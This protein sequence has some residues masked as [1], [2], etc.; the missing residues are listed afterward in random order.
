[1]W[2]RFLIWNDAGL[3]V[4]MRANVDGTARVELARASNATALAVDHNTGTVYYALSRQIHAVDL[5]ASNK[6]V[7]MLTHP[8]TYEINSI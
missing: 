8:T 6:Y 5:D 3:G 2:Y 1:M 7:A 4:I